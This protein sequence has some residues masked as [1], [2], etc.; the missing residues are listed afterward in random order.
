MSKSQ[1]IYIFGDVFKEW[2]EGNIG[3]EAA[4]RALCS[5]LGEVQDDYEALADERDHVRGQISEIVNSLGGKADIAGF[6]ELRIT[7]PATTRSYDRKAI[8]SLVNEL[9]T[10]GYGDIAER[11]LRCEKASMR[12]GSLQIRRT[13]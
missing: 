6:G 1:A 4:L 9:V 12:A 5:Q 7:E 10:E 13:S 2:K 3:P 11:V 8:Q